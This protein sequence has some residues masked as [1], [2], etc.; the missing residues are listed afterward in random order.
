M[1]AGTAAGWGVE[2][3]TRVKS[4]QKQAAGPWQ[5]TKILLTFNLHFAVL[6]T[7]SFHCLILLCVCFAFCVLCSPGAVRQQQ[8]D[9]VFAVS[10]SSCH[11]SHVSMCFWTV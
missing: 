9:E 8:V 5:Q 10:S 1:W 11:C 6:P 2:V 4:H 7:H 3:T